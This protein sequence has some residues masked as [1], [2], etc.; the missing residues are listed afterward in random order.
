MAFP[1]RGTHDYVIWPAKPDWLVEKRGLGFKLILDSCESN[2]NRRPVITEGSDYIKVILF[3]EHIEES[4]PLPEE[5]KALEPYRKRNQP[6]QTGEAKQLLGV[7]I[8]TA[9]SRLQDLVRLGYLKPRGKGRAVK[10][11]WI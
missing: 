2:N 8:N 3:R 4:S 11:Y 10:Y 6:L 7:S 1:M 5:A 9:R